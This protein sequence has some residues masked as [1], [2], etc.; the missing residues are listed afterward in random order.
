MPE[1]SR[2]PNFGANYLQPGCSVI[3]FYYSATEQVRFVPFIAEGLRLGQTVVLAAP[4]DLIPSFTGSLNL[5]G[6]RRRNGE[7]QQVLLTPDISSCLAVLVQAVKEA[8]IGSGLVRLLADFSGL[9]AHEDVFDVEAT[10]S[11][12]LHGLRL[13]SITQYD[14]NVVSAPVTVE[15]FKTHSLA[16]VGDA[17]YYENRRHISPEAYIRKRAAATTAGN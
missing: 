17:F 2:L 9:V 13:M 5:P 10:L 7:L 3:H 14:G 16:I 1:T 15:Q 11:S 8:A 12:S 6:F 4:A